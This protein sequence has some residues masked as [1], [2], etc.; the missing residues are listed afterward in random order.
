MRGL[1]SLKGIQA[2]SLHTRWSG[3]TESRISV[4]R[5]PAVYY[6]TS[7]AESNIGKS[8][9]AMGEARTQVNTQTRGPFGQLLTVVH[10]LLLRWCACPASHVLAAIRQ[11]L[12]PS[13]L[14]VAYASAAQNQFQDPHPS[15]AQLG[16]QI[17][18]EEQLYHR[19]LAL[20]NRT[21]RFPD[22]SRRQLLCQMSKCALCI[23]CLL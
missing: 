21:I 4:V 10:S 11:L 12:W 1:C 9:A 14:T 17:T 23:C 8:V 20:Y 19:W 5:K 2:A 3:A 7:T 6:C 22:V 13:L 18:R 15:A 16:F